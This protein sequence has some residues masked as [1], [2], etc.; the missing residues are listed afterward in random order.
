MQYCNLGSGGI[1][2]SSPCPGAMLS[3]A[4]GSAGHDDPVKIVHGQP[5]LTRARR[6]RRAPAKSATDPSGVPQP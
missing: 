1:K 6:C 5:V 3:G 4:W 2:D